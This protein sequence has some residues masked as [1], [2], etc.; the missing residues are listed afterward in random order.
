VIGG[1]GGGTPKQAPKGYKPPKYQSDWTQ[2]DD[3]VWVH[4]S[5]FTWNQTNFSPTNNGLNSTGYVY[6]PP[7]TPKKK[8]TTYVTKYYTAEEIAYIEANKT[9]YPQWTTPPT[10]AQTTE[11]PQTTIFAIGITSVVVVATLPVSLPTLAVAGGAIGI[12]SL[13]AAG[14]KFEIG[15]NNKG[16]VENLQDKWNEKD[17]K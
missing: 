10:F 7:W 17:K 9:V 11:I 3:G 1:G 15:V 6:T 5:G 16:L 14:E 8:K 12:M 13:S 4:K 2:R